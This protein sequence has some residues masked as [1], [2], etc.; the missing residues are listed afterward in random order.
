MK[1]IHI[2]LGLGRGGAEKMLL[3]IASNQKKYVNQT[4][5][6]LTNIDSFHEEFA[7]EGIKVIYLSSDS[8][9]SKFF[10]PVKLIRQLYKIEPNIIQCWMYHAEL[11]GTIA[12]FFYFKKTKIFWNI[13]CS[14][15]DWKDRNIMNSIFFRVLVALSHLP[16]KIICNTSE[17]I[18]NHIKEG[19]SPKNFIKIG[20]GFNLSKIRNEKNKTK[21]ILKEG[22]RYIIMVA[23]Y[24]KVKDHKTLIKAFDDL[25]KNNEFQDVRLV[26][27]GR[28]DD[29]GIYQHINESKNND[30]IYNVGEVDNVLE[31]ISECDIGTLTSLNEGFPNVIGEYIMANLPVVATNVGEVKELIIDKNNLF[32]PG[33]FKGISN[34][35]QELFR[36]KKEAKKNTSINLN[37]LKERFSINNISKKYLSLYEEF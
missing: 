15:T 30:K 33:D 19:Y 5:L 3:K 14:N 12:R 21:N 32:E 37:N 11:L 8:F 20:N 23:R 10:I 4:I 34:R 18:S 29:K 27:L 22:L 24:R 36:M 1:I 17:G 13:R 7:K 2:I 25:Q 31:Y 6:S 28:P 9:F 26:L 35:W 16:N